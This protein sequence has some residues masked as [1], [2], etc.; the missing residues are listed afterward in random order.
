MIFL[1]GQAL[2][3]GWSAFERHLLADGQAGSGQYVETKV[4]A[5]FASLVVLF[6]EDDADR[7]RR[8]SWK[9]RGQGAGH[10]APLDLPR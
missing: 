3:A 7:N 6:G 4:A 5:A 9:L 1:L 2:S 10:A 8:G